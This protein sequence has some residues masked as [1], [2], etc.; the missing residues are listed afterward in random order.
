M[1]DTLYTTLLD[2][3]LEMPVFLRRTLAGLPR[4]DLLRQP[5]HDKSPL[6]EHLWHT[7]DCETLLY[8]LRIRRILAQDRPPLEP[9]NVG[10]W[11]A[12][13]GYAARDGDAAITA[14]ESARAELLAVLRALTPAQ[15]ARAGLRADGV[16]VSVLALIG[17]LLAHDQDHRWR[18]T[19]ILREYAGLPALAA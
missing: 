8:G 9:V 15:L 13:H 11:P 17:Q 3:L 6:I 7:T 1:I 14:F 12:L 4:E 16:E 5:A 10:E 2:Q 18:V 19:A